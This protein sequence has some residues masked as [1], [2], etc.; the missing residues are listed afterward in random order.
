MSLTDAQI[1]DIIDEARRRWMLGDSSIELVAARENQVFRVQTPI[2]SYALRLHRRRYRSVDEIHSELLWMYRLAVKEIPVPGS[3][4]AVDGNSVQII[5]D[6]VVDMLTW[7]EGTPLSKIPV[8][9]DIY[10]QLGRMLAKMHEATDSWELPELFQRPTWDLVGDEPS[11]GKFWDNPQ[12]SVVQKAKLLK[13][14][15][16]ARYTL[17]NM[18][19]VDFGL[20][21]ADLVP[22][23]VLYN[24]YELQPIDFDDGGFGYRLF[25][26]ATI[27][28]RSRRIPNGDNLA[29][30][31]TAGYCKHRALDENAVTESLPL[32][33]AMRSCSY[34]GWSIARMGEPGAIE[35]NE[36]FIVEAELAVNKY[37]NDSK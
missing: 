1:A 23:N 9:E 11:W 36:R 17:E 18:Q 10:F 31:A 19:Q 7:L 8:T 33:E 29:N 4:S 14:R 34:L 13:F 26:L 30:A 15:D 25:D 20:I 16:D 27:T 35:R 28:N 3:V 2:A 32:F 21:H 37:F 22:D 5:N 12:L 6:I 24:G